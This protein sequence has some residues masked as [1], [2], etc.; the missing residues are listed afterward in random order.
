M[1]KTVNALNSNARTTA[2]SDVIAARNVVIGASLIAVL[3]ALLLASAFARQIT[4]P[5][6]ELA[7][8]AIA[9][10]NTGELSRSPASN[11]LNQ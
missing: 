5:L 6:T 2:A 7:N 10:R 11:T 4:G 8:H 1:Q 3:G 9:I